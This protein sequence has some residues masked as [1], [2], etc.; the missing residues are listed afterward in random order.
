[1]LPTANVTHDANGKGPYDG[2]SLSS[3]CLCQEIQREDMC[4]S[5]PKFI[6]NVLVMCIS[7][8]VA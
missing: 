8:V 4:R 5:T 1:M 7:N 2:G 6:S 3:S